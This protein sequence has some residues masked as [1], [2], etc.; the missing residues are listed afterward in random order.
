MTSDSKKFKQPTLFELAFDGGY[1]AQESGMRNEQR[2][3]SQEYV[4]PATA[5]LSKSQLQ[6]PDGLQSSLLQTAIRHARE[7]TADDN[8]RLLTTMQDD[9]RDDEL[10]T[11]SFPAGDPEGKRGRSSRLHFKEIGFERITGFAMV[12]QGM[13]REVGVYRAFYF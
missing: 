11:R 7:L 3:L 12:N 2:Q 10:D 6:E 13:T 5:T 8:Y 9:I 4:Q 1:A